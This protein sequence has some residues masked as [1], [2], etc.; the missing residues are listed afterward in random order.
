[1]L[2]QALHASSHSSAVALSLPPRSRRLPRL[3]RT[4][5]HDPAC[6]RLGYRDAKAQFAP[7]SGDG[8]AGQLI[9]FGVGVSPL[10]R[11]PMQAGAPEAVTPCSQR[12]SLALLGLSWGGFVTPMATLAEAIL[13]NRPLGQLR[14]FTIHCQLPDSNIRLC[15]GVPDGRTRRTIT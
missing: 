11:N 8:A 4:G 3:S 5:W 13:S 9:G 7:A 10:F 14:T 1:M 6:R 2:L 12:Y 15:N